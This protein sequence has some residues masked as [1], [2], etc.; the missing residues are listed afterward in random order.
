MALFL[1]FLVT[2]EPWRGVAMETESITSW[3]R[4]SLRRLSNNHNAVHHQRCSQRGAQAAGVSQPWMAT[5]VQPQ[6]SRV[7]KHKYL[8]GLNP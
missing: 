1:I 3:S 4:D 7:L 8:R 6:A 2:M 5:R